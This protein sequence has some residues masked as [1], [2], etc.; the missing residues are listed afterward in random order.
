MS[1]PNT[2]DHHA[3]IFIALVPWV[4]FSVVCRISVDAASLLALA[5]SAVIAAPGIKAGRP[6]IL[7]LAAV[8]SFAGFAA[9]VL[10]ID[11]GA[12]DTLHRYARAIAAGLLALIAFGSLLFTPFTE[13]YAREALPERVW[14]TAKFKAGNRAMTAMWGAV[15]AAMVPCHIIAGSL[16][17]TRSNLIFN[18]VIPVALVMWA[19]KRSTV[20]AEAAATPTHA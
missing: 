12:A 2:S 18:W 11:P 9:V 7:E 16:D 1:Q 20:P 14:N 10:A 15:F 6:K 4:L 19:I 17:T 3:G 5:A 8:V 13:Q